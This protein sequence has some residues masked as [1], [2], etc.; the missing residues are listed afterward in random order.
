MF[1]A[2]APHRGLEGQTIG[3]YEIIARIG[4]GGTGVVYKARQTSL[5]RP[6]AL[7]ILQPALA[8]D[9]EF[10]A[11]FHREAKAAAALNHM[12]L[13]QVHAAGETDEL[14]WFAME[15]VEG[16]SALARLKRKERLDPAE[17]IAISIHVA[18]A[19]EYGW[20]KAHLI[21]R[22]IK[23]DNIFLSIDGEVKLGDLGL[24]KSA[25][26]GQSLTMTG[27]SMG[28]PYYISPEQGLGK[29]D[30]DLRTDI[31]SLGC[32]LFHLVTGRTP[33]SGDT[34]LAVM[35][36]HVNEPVPDPLKA[37]PEFPAEL[38]HVVVKM[39]AKNPAERQ[40]D[41][42][43]VIADLRRAYDALT[44]A[45]MAPEKI[46][47]TR[48][49]QLQPAAQARMPEAIEVGLPR[50]KSKTLFISV[51]LGV[52]AFF[53]FKKG[54][55]NVNGSNDVG[56][57]AAR[58]VDLLP[59]VDVKR[60]VISGTW[61]VVPE[62][63][64]RS[65]RDTGA[66]RLEFPY[67]PPA[68][69]DFDLEFTVEDGQ[70]GYVMQVLAVPK[71]WL[72][73]RLLPP[74]VFGPALD[75]VEPGHRPRTEGIGQLSKFKPGDR[76]RSTVEV[77]KGS[78]RAIVDGKEIASYTGDFKRLSDPTEFFK[79]NDTTHVGVG[80][81]DIGLLV[82]KA[83]VREISGAG[84][85]NFFAADKQSPVINNWRDLTER[86]REKA[87]AFPNL[88]IE[89]GL[90]RHNG[91][92]A[93]VSIPLTSPGVSDYAVRLR[94]V[95]DGEI[96]LRTGLDGS[97]YVLCQRHQ[98]IFHHYEIGASAPVLLRP[99]VPHPSNYDASQPHDLLVTMKG[100]NL[101]VWLDDHFVGE[102]NDSKF[103]KGDAKLVF[104]RW[105]VVKRVEVAEDVK[106]VT[107]P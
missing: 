23:P 83:T 11:R 73:W 82:H 67:A 32:T 101:R 88:V 43:E 21:H 50:W 37:W 41:Y 49:P 98:T 48:P 70:S 19:L 61:T 105:S 100:P 3:E 52:V 81:M 38:A 46:V 92:G 91:N 35:L 47:V 76:H 84:N 4:R 39:M 66:G 80:V 44:G 17:A 24:A 69:Y 68:E 40:Q 1:H 16:E 25:G 75:G 78:L 10:I 63:G 62:G 14:H 59:L 45:T 74:P 97:L 56:R 12:N 18:T 107:K 79:L 89:P 36:Q 34:P 55:N 60:D 77:R 28:T 93:Q 29:K 26:G 106:P 31:Y 99:N 104:T 57:A 42:V 27:V 9:A 103:Q 85:E 22:D 20:R 95:G 94:F 5:D 7:K 72:G 65:V 6:V 2:F 71:H 13:V 86:V 64:F 15:F 87:R 58:I 33:Y 30:V 90:V 102:A 51:L 53:A 96:T 8:D 54:T